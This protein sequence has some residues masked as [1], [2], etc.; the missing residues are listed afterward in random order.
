MFSVSSINKFLFKN[1]PVQLFWCLGI[2]LIFGDILPDYIIS[3]FYTLSVLIKDLL[4]YI[5]PAIIFSYL[6][7]ALVSFKKQAPLLILSVFVLIILSNAIGVLTSYG[8][9]YLI[10]PFIGNISTA[11]SQLI[12]NSIHPIFNLDIKPLITPEIALMA[13]ILIGMAINFLPVEEKF[14]DFKSYIF[15]LRNLITV[16]LRKCFIPLLPFYILGFVFKLQKEG[17]LLTL[18]ENYGKILIII[19]SLIAIYILFLYLLAANFNVRK[20]IS[21]LKEMAPAGLTAFSTMSSAA[22]MPLTLEA[23]ERNLRDRSYADFIIPTTVNNHMVGDALSTPLTALFLLFMSGQSFPDLKTYLIFVFY[24]CLAKF[25]AAGI[26][27]GGVI[28]ILP[29]VQAY[30]GL[31]EQMTSLLA[32]IYI[33]K[34]PLLTATNVM[35]NGAFALIS[36]KIINPLYKK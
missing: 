5:L 10:S 20:A 23:T 11:H 28:V 12:T 26:P 21:Y 2:G 25:S 13:G 17:A 32:T 18:L 30:L 29:V 7:A 3:Y 15:K 9:A 34:D 16:F 1:L 8:T 24:Y 19:C 31:N 36:R 6:L 27:G 4:M 35:G 14:P 33:L 22:T